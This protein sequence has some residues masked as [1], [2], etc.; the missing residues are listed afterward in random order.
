MGHLSAETLARIVDEAPLAEEAEHLAECGTCSR[1]LQAL[2]AQTEA[3]RALPELLPPVGD[4]DVLEARLRSEGLIQDP[5]LFT[6]LGLARTPGWM[7]TAAGVALFLGGA[8]VGAGV[9]AHGLPGPVQGQRAQLAENATVQ[10][11]ADAM[12][13]AESQYI[14]AL[15]RYR[16]ILAKDGDDADAGDPASRYAALQYLVAASQAAVRQAPAD[17]F[18]NGMLASTLAESQA[19]ASRISRKD[20]WF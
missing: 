8:A 17:P 12:R 16:E 3:L 7:R 19:V 15:T 14:S 18:L 1:E 11:A 9:T 4:W 13:A 20:N 10:D 6:R 5:G 2:K